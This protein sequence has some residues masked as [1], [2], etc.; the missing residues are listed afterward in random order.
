MIYISIAF[1][2]SFVSLIAFQDWARSSVDVFRMQ[3]E[4]Y[5]KKFDHSSEL[6]LI[7]GSSEVANLNMTFIQNNVSQPNYQ[8]YNLGT[9]ADVP[10]ER[11]QTID[12]IIDLH[13]KLV[14]YGIGIRDFMERSEI[15]LQ[16]DKPKNPLPDVNQLYDLF[17]GTEVKLNLESPKFLSLKVIDSFLFNLMGISNEDNI[18]KDRTPF[19]L[20]GKDVYEIKNTADIESDFHKRP[21]LRYVEPPISNVELFALKQTVMKLQENNIKVVFFTTPKARVYFDNLSDKQSQVFDSILAELENNKVKIYRLDDKYVDM[22]IWFDYRHVAIDQ[23]GLIYSKDIAEIINN[24]LK[25][26]N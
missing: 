11:L 20:H 26:L 16:L 3:D 21:A 10:T 14:V 7:L 15:Q 25:D 23:H 24:E 22:N 9:G 12:K 2:L 5:S 17:N 4:F 19:Y 8:V 13:P 6:I 18:I 1:I